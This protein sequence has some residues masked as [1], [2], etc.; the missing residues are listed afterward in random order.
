VAAIRS[1]W[2]AAPDEVRRF[3]SVEQDGSFTLQK[4]WID[5]KL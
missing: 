4:I 5:A 2:K 1:L 3:F